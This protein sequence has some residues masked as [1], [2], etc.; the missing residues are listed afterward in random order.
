MIRLYYPRLPLF[1]DICERLS[2]LFQFRRHLLRLG[3]R[4]SLFTSETNR[5]PVS[6]LQGLSGLSHLVLEVSLSDGPCHLNLLLL[7]YRL[8]LLLCGLSVLVVRLRD[9]N[10]F[11]DGVRLFD[12]QLDT[13][14]ALFP[15]L[16]FLVLAR[17]R[18]F[19]SVGDSP[20]PRGLYNVLQGRERA[21]RTGIR[22]DE[23]DAFV[24]DAFVA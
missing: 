19:R 5:H 16:D 23:A 21:Q 7:D 3:V 14:P 8:F 13:V 6:L 10:E 15:P 20:P 17:S 2:R 11:D 9:V 1:R 24:R 12:D 22:V 18:L 4:L